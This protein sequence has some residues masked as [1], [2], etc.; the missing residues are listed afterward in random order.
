MRE[1]TGR[2]KFISFVNRNIGKN[3]TTANIANKT[4]LGLR[5]VQA[6]CKSVRETSPNKVT[7]G[8]VI[9]KNG[10]RAIGYTFR[11]SI[12]FIEVSE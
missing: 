5:R 3:L 10:N 7:Y 8:Y 6:M 9:K 2:A 12:E 1:N 11:K 4:K